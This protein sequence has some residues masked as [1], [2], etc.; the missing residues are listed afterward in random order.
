MLFAIADPP[1]LGQAK[2][3]PEHPEAAIWDE[4]QTHLNLLH[5][6]E[7]EYEGWVLACTVPMLTLLLPLAPKGARVG[8][9]AKTRTG[10]N[11]PNVRVGYAFEHVLWKHLQ[12]DAAEWP[13]C[14]GQTP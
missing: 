14:D 8:V 6:L 9:W 11:R 4:P 5:R 2:R 7:D 3:Y 10:G 13:T 12:E 1:Y